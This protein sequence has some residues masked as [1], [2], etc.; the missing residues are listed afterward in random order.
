MAQ[1]ECGQ[2]PRP[3]RRRSTGS[4]TSRCRSCATRVAHHN[5]GKLLDDPAGPRGHEARRDRREP[6]LPLLP[7]PRRRRLRDRPVGDDARRRARGAHVRDA[8]HRHHRLLAPRQGDRASRDL[9][10]RHPLRADPR[11]GRAAPL[12]HRSPHRAHPRSGARPRL[13]ARA[14]RAHRDGRPPH[15]GPPGGRTKYPRRPLPQTTSTTGATN[16][17]LY[18]RE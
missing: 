11:A 3:E 4:S 16:C 10:L 7:R 12:E 18:S 6:P 13:R 14:H 1:V 17:E 9:R 2:V 15:R 5:T 8:R